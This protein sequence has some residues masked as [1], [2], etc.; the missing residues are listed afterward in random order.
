MHKWNRVKGP[1]RI[2]RA[3][4]FCISGT[5]SNGL[6]RRAVATRQMFAD[7][8]RGSVAFSH[9]VT[10][11]VRLACI[12]GRRYVNAACRHVS[13]DVRNRLQK[14]RFYRACRPGWHQ[15][16]SPRN[17]V[18]FSALER[19]CLVPVKYSDL[20]ALLQRRRAR[21]PGQ[22]GLSRSALCHRCHAVP[23]APRPRRAPETPGHPGHTGPRR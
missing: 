20:M 16:G 9:V 5:D 11:V 3:S 19:E 17:C 13:L 10:G 12:P 4:A 1:I 2:G 8:E 14:S 7:A 23:T 22:A 6:T 18:R 15:A 21:R